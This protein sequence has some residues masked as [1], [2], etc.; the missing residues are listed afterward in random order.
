MPAR[1]A[2]VA[3]SEC[4]GSAQA[5]K[6]KDGRERATALDVADE[7]RQA[8]APVGRGRPQLES[9]ALAQQQGEDKQNNKDQEQ[10]FGD[11]YGR[12]SDAAKTQDTGDYRDDEE[13]QRVMQHEKFLCRK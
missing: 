8:T 11:S 2:E 5:F 1:N 3:E 9:A 12:S 4:C 7:Y 13:Y 6:P 10:Y